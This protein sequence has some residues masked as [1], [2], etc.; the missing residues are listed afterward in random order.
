M[1]LIERPGSRDGLELTGKTVLDREQIHPLSSSIEPRVANVML[2]VADKGGTAVSNAYVSWSTTLGRIS[3][4]SAT[5]T[6]ELGWAWAGFLSESPGKAVITA[7]VNKQGYREL[8][9]K[10]EVTVLKPGRVLRVSNTPELGDIFLDG[11]RI[12]NGKAEFYIPETGIYQV[13]WGGIDGYRMPE[14]VKVYSNNEYAASPVVIDGVYRKISEL[15]DSVRL[16]VFV[17]ITYDDRTGIPNPLPGAKV[18]LSDGQVGVADYSGGV[19]FKVKPN[20]IIGVKAFHPNSWGV[21]HEIQV[22]IGSSDKHVN[23]DFGPWFGG[24]ESTDSSVEEES[25]ECAA[26]DYE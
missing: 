1:A 15:P 14:P 18:Q 24:E 10:T 16:V 25:D 13:S 5:R 7:R 17:L 9:L 21:D 12:G 22:E 4:S 20:T 23:L 2:H 3:E 26:D 19:E 6:D 11:T 8:E